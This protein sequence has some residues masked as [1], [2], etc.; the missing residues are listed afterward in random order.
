MAKERRKTERKF[1]CTWIP[2]YLVFIPNSEVYGTW[3]RK[4][5][6]AYTTAP[7]K[8]EKKKSRWTL[9][10]SSEIQFNSRYQAGR[11]QLLLNMRYLECRWTQQTWNISLQLQCAARN[12]ENEISI[13]KI[14]YGTMKPIQ[15]STWYLIHLLNL[16]LSVFTSR[17]WQATYA[18]GPKLEGGRAWGGC[19][20]ELMRGG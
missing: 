7:E 12:W 11:C 6:D 18:N 1:R 8:D 10:T 15:N 14:Y 9:L 20:L 16:F 4:Q 2:A 13:K 3:F 19:L 5:I 17:A